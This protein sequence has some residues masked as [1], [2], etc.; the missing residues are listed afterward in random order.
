MKGNK[1]EHL[2]VELS[3]K[4]T[5]MVVDSVHYFSAVYNVTAQK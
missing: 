3:I 2:N 4:N 1:P 5:E